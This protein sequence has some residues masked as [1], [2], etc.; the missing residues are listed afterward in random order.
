M[1]IIGPMT[2]LNNS[3]KS[4]WLYGLWNKMNLV[5]MLIKDPQNYCHKQKASENSKYGYK[6]SK[7]ICADRGFWNR[8]AADKYLMCPP[9]WWK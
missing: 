9:L 5:N 1:G 3:A 2:P 4:K 8:F 6:W 7:Q